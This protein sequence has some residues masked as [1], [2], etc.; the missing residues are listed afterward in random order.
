[1]GVAMLHAVGPH[2][3][4]AVA[5][6]AHLAR[7]AR[8]RRLLRKGRV[9]GGLLRQGRV[10][11]LLRRGGLL[12]K[13]GLLGE[14]GLLRKRGLLG[15]RSVER[16]RFLVGQGCLLVHAWLNHALMAQ[17]VLVE[18]LLGRNALGWGGLVGHGTL[19]GLKCWGCHD[20]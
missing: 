19:L 3:Q 15:E 5:P 13:E 8:E 20:A 1:M 11:R 12:R 14:R 18:G 4:E 7:H 6:V 17:A 10:G 16:N 2:A 9:L